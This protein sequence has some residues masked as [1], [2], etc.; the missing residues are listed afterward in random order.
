MGDLVAN[1]AEAAVNFVHAFGYVGVAVLI[2]LGNLHLPVP[3]QL[4]LPLAGFL[5]GQGRF[6]ILPLMA[7]STAAAI[8]A[9]LMMYA[10]GLWIGEENLRRLVA[11]FGRF[12]LVRGSDLDRAMGSFEK[13]GGKA[14]LI[15]HFV[16]GV[17]AFIS[18]P[19][20]MRRMPIFGRFMLYTIVGCTL[21]NGAHVALGW[22]LGDNWT[23]VRDYARVVEYA[24]LAAAV[25]GI[26]WFMYRRWKTR[27]QTQ[28]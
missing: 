7:W 12:L 26:V 2:V 27:R 6:E 24:V 14:V 11:R 20:G 5:V 18:I 23:V 13:H 3:T 9:S 25:G 22:V 17:G 15:G 10:V 28:P 4:V 19:A 1:L 8:L 21:W 16:P